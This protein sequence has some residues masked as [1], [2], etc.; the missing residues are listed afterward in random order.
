MN[1]ARMPKRAMHP[2]RLAVAAV[3]TLLEAT[4]RS[5]PNAT[6]PSALRPLRQ[7]RARTTPLCRGRRATLDGRSQWCF[8]VECDSEAVAAPSPNRQRG[9]RDHTDLTVGA[10]PGA[11]GRPLAIA[12]QVEGSGALRDRMVMEGVGGGYPL[13]SDIRFPTLPQGR[14]SP[15]QGTPP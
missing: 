15:R 8:T 5:V 13:G 14:M 11:A 4:G 1:S 7:P 10:R 3:A 6:R 2:L 9:P 12:A